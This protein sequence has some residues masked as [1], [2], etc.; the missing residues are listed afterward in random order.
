MGRDAHFAFRPLPWSRRRVSFIERIEH[1]LMD[2]PIARD[3]FV[4]IDR[5]VASGEVGQ[6]PSGFSKDHRPGGHIPRV[7]FHFPES[8]KTPS[9]DVA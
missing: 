8:V 1:G 4:P 6:A 2:V 7:E 5:E 3:Q 9:G